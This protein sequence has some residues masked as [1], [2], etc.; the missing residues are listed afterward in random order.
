MPVAA[1]SP[2]LPPHAAPRSD[3]LSSSLLAAR[4]AAT[5]VMKHHTRFKEDD[6]TP[7][8]INRL[9][10][11]SSPYL[12][13]HAFNPVD[14]YPWGPE[15]L[16]RA[17]ET[18]RPIF[19]SIGYSTCHWCHVMARE[20]FE[21][22]EVAA[23]INQHYVP[24]KVDREERPDLDRIYMSVVT[25]LTGS[26]G[27]PMTVVL[28]PELEPMFGGTYFPPRDGEGRRPGLLGLL[29]K[30]QGVWSDDPEAARTK[31]K[32]LAGRLAARSRPTPPTG[33]PAAELP[34]KVA[35]GVM[36][37]YD[38]D[39]GGFGRAPKF[40]RVAN[41]L[42]LLRQAHRGNSESFRIAV[43]RTLDAMA[44]GG[45]HDWV[46]GG[47]HRYSVDGQ[48]R[49]PHFEKML[50][51]NAQLAW[52]YLEAA[53]AFDSDHY[54]KVAVRTL[55]YLL[56]EMRAPDGGFFSATDADSLPFG[57]G[58]DGAHGKKEEG[59]FFTWR[60]DEIL[61]VLGPS[62]GP[63]FNETFHVT[64]GGNFEFG[65]T[66]LH[67]DGPWEG[68]P[69]AQL[70]KA[71]ALVDAL[72]TLR[73]ARARRP[74]PEVDTKRVTAWNA[75]TIS[76][77]ARAG[78]LLRRDDY[79]HE[80]RGAMTWLLEKVWTGERLYRTWLAGRAGGVAVIRDYAFTVQALLDLFEADSDV[81][82]LR[83]ALS[84]QEAQDRIFLDK[85]WGGYEHVPPE[86]GLWVRRT[87]DYDGAEPSGNSVA[88]HNL[89]RLHTLTTRDEFR[90]AADQLFKAFG[91]RLEE[92]GAGTPLMIDALALR[93]GGARELVIVA[94]PGRAPATNALYEVA[95][96]IYAPEVIHVPVG[97]GGVDHFA[98]RVVP[99]LQGKVARDG[100]PTA[101]L[102]RERV[103]KRPTIDP[104][105]LAELLRE[106]P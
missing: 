17:R 21:D 75:L 18:N 101:Y 83:A 53:V 88:A 81:R 47:F 62:V 26:G 56:R 20:S 61:D 74:P 100:A 66:Q 63:R 69:S 28:T 15:A 105:V 39:H 93:H 54:R 46:G 58:H 5:E 29:Q 38:A 98:A 104:A 35:Y 95:R 16:K 14:W 51:D 19:L 8:F 23:Y 52:L 94:A 9:A 37:S 77:L 27:W 7:V 103:C 43:A 36:R 1:A 68:E 92:G 13:Q 65:R 25:L 79:L 73:V 6:G 30:I 42:F 64:A 41:L 72:D 57:A 102:C 86:T 33:V 59:F 50:Y 80:A 60:P 22:M 90:A 45:L 85:D 40:P 4:E 44:T 106:R 91:A 99:W 34:K 96:T 78:R 12:L 87:S 67:L 84:V 70:D 71:W 10:A 11:V 3:E 2:P 82:W 97:E 31:A 55:D 32:Q 76:A 24:V 89:L 48:W 49:I